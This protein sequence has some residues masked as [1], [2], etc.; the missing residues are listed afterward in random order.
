MTMPYIYIKKQKTQLFFVGVV[1]IKIIDKIF[2]KVLC[3]QDLRKMCCDYT[4]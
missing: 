1:A 4:V 3:S 2:S